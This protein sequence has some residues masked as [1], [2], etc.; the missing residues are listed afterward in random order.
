[1]NVAWHSLTHK[2]FDSNL[3]Q[4]GSYNLAYMKWAYG[5]KKVVHR[6]KEACG[7][8]FTKTVTHSRGFCKTQQVSAINQYQFSQRK[9]C[10]IYEWASTL[11]SVISIYIVKWMSFSGGPYV[12]TQSSLQI[13][14]C[15][16]VEFAP[17]TSSY[18]SRSCADDPLLCNCVAKA[19]WDFI[20][21]IL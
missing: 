2:I 20:V 12:F 18:L 6:L 10:S 16:V 15:P 9:L 14:P 17:K 4:Q 1:M 7:L 11:Q 13:H 19:S 8:Y 3:F 5:L 21:C